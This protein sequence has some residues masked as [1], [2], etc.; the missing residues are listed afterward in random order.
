MELVNAIN[1]LEF[2]LQQNTDRD[3]KDFLL[4]N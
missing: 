1:A 4:H 2:L 3:K